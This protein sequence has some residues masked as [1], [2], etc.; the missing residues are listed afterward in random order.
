ML[1][2]VQIEKLF[3]IACC[4]I[5][6]VAFIQFPTD[7]FALN[8][9]DYVS[10]FLTLFSALRGGQTR[11]LQLLVEKVSEVF[12]SANLGLSSNSM[13]AVPSNIG[14]DLSSISSITSPS[15]PSTELIRQLAAQTSAQLPLN[16]SQHSLL[17]TVG[18]GKPEPYFQ[19]PIEQSMLFSECWEFENLESNKSKNAYVKSEGEYIEV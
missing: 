17:N 1:I 4:L 9:R 10:Q 6:A 7:T 3:D 5:D 13:G 2:H 19:E 8:P 18:E 12:P 11:Y 16:T 15:Y 14:D